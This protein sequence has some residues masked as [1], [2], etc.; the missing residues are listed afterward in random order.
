MRPVCL[1][2]DLSL[3]I[4][5]LVAGA[6][7]W[8]F[9]WR[10]VAARWFPRIAGAGRICLAFA[11]GVFATVASHYVLGVLGLYFPLAGLVVHVVLACGAWV[12]IRSPGEAGENVKS[13]PVVPVA[14]LIAA[15]VTLYIRLPDPLSHH[16]L[17][18]NDPWGHLVLCKALERGDLLASHHFFSYYPRGY[19]FLVL[20]MAELTRGSVY[21]IMRLSGPL[22]SLIGVIGAY[23]VGKRLASTTG[24]LLAAMVYAIPPYQHLVL[25]ALQTALEPDRVSFVLLPA[26]LLVLVETMESGEN[27]SAGFLLAGGIC[28]VLIHPLSVQFLVGW[29]FLAGIAV[30]AMKRRWREGAACMLPAVVIIVFAWAYYRVMHGVYGMTPMPHL[31]PERALTIGGHGVDLHRLVLG[32]G[33]NVQ[34]GD[35]AA[36]V[37]VVLL[38]VLAVRRRETGLLALALILFHTL[39]AAVTDALYIGDFGHVPP[40]YAMVFA[41]SVGAGLGR[42]DLSRAWRFL[43]AVL[44]LGVLV[45]SPFSKDGPVWLKSALIAV[46]AAGSLWVLLRRRFLEFLLPLSVGTTLLAVR[47]MP[48]KY[49]H[50]GYPEAVAWA[51]K[52]RSC[53]PGVVYS[54][55]LIS[56]LPDGAPFPT[57]N[58]IASIVW[59]THTPRELQRL[60]ALPA[61]DGFREEERAFVFVEREAYDWSFPYYEK[62]DRVAI[63]HDVEAW[64]SARGAAGATVRV[65]AQSDRMKL[66]A[67]HLREDGECQHFQ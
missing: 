18:G 42:R 55:R 5:V 19:H 33:V 50:L 26:F 61:D 67:L 17:G 22:L 8:V 31:A 53:P 10:G 21:E 9:P 57:Q 38:V 35:L 6:L 66:V 62:E 48:V 54:L 58:P 29:M 7:L 4:R 52:L 40:Y 45:S 13:G 34:T 44:F 11:V 24:G 46:L 27:R 20:I 2:S 39:Y 14:L 60:M 63:F 15:L 36:L 23:A 1:G 59:P 32:T 56:R 64:L 25:P 43:P 41:W 3:L 47:P 51:L 49:A 12:F 30:I 37:F 65:L 16:A 28:L